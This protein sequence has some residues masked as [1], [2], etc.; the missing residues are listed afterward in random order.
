MCSDSQVDQQIRPFPTSRWFSKWAAALK[1]GEEPVES[2]LAIL[3][4]D[5]PGIGNFDARRSFRRIS[6]GHA[7]EASKS[8][9]LAAL[10]GECASWASFRCAPAQGPPLQ[11]SS[12]AAMLQALQ[13]MPWH[14][15]CC[16]AHVVHLGFHSKVMDGDIQAQ[17]AH[18]QLLSLHHLPWQ[19]QPIK[20]CHRTS[21]VAT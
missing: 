7:P 2:K 11:H 15:R 19:Q 16:G 1:P 13:R 21:G 14:R 20:T 9:T 12:T 17:K 6:C 10:P 3:R 5:S 18:V 8:G 4:Q